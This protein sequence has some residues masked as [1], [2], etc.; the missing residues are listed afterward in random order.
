MPCKI[1]GQIPDISNDI[2][3]GLNINDWI[4]NKDLRRIDR[5]I[6]YGLVAAQMAIEDSKWAPSNVKDSE[7]TGVLVGSGIGGDYED[8]EDIS[9]LQNNRKSV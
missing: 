2:E 4:D 1:A 9:D 8:V 6:A 5:F 3:G 7:K